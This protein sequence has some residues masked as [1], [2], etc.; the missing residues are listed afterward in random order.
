MIDLARRRGALGQVFGGA[1]PRHIDF[2]ADDGE[3]DRRSVRAEADDVAVREQQVAGDLLAVDE[4]AVPA[5]E[6]LQH[7]P[8]RFA[9]DRRMPRRHVE[10]AL[11]VEAHVGEWMAADAD[12]A[13]AECFDLPRAGAGEKLELCFHRRSVRYQM[14]ARVVAINASTIVRVCFR[15]SLLGTGGRL[16]L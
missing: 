1:H 3:L 5:A 10:V 13:L 4:G 16:P 14:T 11:G 2:G 7:E 6:I 8:F 12:V 9:Y 15:V